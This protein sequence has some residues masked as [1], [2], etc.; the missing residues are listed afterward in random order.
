MTRVESSASTLARLSFW[1]PAER[2]AEFEAAYEARLAPIL[3]KAG[4]VASSVPGRATVEGVFSRLFAMETPSEVAV[5]ERALRK[6][7]AWQEALQCLGPAFGTAGPGELIRHHFRFYQ[8]PAGAGRAVE[9][10]EGF[11]QGLW[12]TFSVRDG[13]P[14]PIGNSLLQDRSGCVW[15]GTW[16][17]GA[18]L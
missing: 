2:M 3:K 10:G 17:G 7:P 14:T 15:I 11:R 18:T 1:V 9:A 13:L 16:S 8:G 6:D 12:Q 4:L 5:R